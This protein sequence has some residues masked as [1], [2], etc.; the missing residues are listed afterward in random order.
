VIA[1]GHHIN[2]RRTDL[3]SGAGVDARSTSGVLSIND[4]EIR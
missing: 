1:K 4:N 2:T 3:Q